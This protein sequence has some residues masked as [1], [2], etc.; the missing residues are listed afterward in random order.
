[1]TLQDDANW[2]GTI[3]TLQCCY[4][5]TRWQ[6]F[7]WSFQHFLIEHLKWCS[8]QQNRHN[9]QQKSNATPICRYN[10]RALHDLT[11]AFTGIKTKSAKVGLAVYHDWINEQW[12]HQTGIICVCQWLQLRGSE[13]I[14]I[15]WFGHK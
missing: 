7:L 5:Q 3:W 1:M 12:I 2:K 15:P 10:Y 6:P 13:L 14:Y 9:I 8:T 4:F 11:A